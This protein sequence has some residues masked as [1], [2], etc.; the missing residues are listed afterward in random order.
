M[1]DIT[2]TQAVRFAGPKVLTMLSSPEKHDNPN[3]VDLVRLL[4]CT[5]IEAF[6]GAEERHRRPQ[7]TESP[8]RRPLHP[9]SQ[10]RLQVW[11]PAVF[12]AGATSR[13][14]QSQSQERPP[15]VFRED[16]VRALLPDI[17]A[18][19]AK[20]PNA[21]VRQLSN[22]FVF[23]LQ[24]QGPQ[25]ELYIKQ[26]AI[27]ERYPTK[28]PPISLSS[29]PPKEARKRPSPPRRKCPKKSGGEKR[30]GSES[31]T[32]AA[33]A[34]DSGPAS[35]RTEERVRRLQSIREVRARYDRPKNVSPSKLV[36]TSMAADEPKSGPAEI[37]EETRTIDEK[38]PPPPPPAKKRSSATKKKT[39]PPVAKTVRQP[40]EEPIIQPKPRP[41]PVFVAPD[42]YTVWL[43]G[44][45][46]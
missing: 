20:K 16:K 6:W 42:F 32:T 26:A 41:G 17:M 43:R 45:V 11:D 28:P 3:V 23:D 8:L 13:N 19:L 33:A 24:G 25:P 37:P 2:Q 15:F 27:Q 10:E 22:P 38:K 12:A 18:Q 14:S 44:N 7:A 9:S 35:K 36:S 31:R 4:F 46:V 1:F 21:K 40:K 30:P 5:W 34:P 29:Q 39:S